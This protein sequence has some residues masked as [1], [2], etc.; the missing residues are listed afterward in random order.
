MCDLD[1]DG[2]KEIVAVL[3]LKGQSDLRALAVYQLNGRRYQKVA[4]HRLPN[5]PALPYPDLAALCQHHKVASLQLNE[6]TI[7]CSSSAIG[8]TN[9]ISSGKW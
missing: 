6:A 8:R 2:T 4:Q 7:R 9:S 3:D 5:E 1:G